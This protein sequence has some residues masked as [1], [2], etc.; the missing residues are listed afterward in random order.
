MPAEMY[1]LLL[2]SYIR[3]PEEKD[4]LFRAIDTIPCVQKKAEWCFKWIS[5]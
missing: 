4:S 2:E 3:D 5:R 1:A